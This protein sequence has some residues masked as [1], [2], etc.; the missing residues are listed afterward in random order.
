M[1]IH[2]KQNDYYDGVAAQYYDKGDF[3]F[4]RNSEEIIYKKFSI[5]CKFIYYFGLFR[6][7]FI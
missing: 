2:S 7:R 6:Y 3:H 4:V 1:I 5:F